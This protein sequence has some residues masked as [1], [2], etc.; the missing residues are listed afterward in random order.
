ML[1]NK[2]YREAITLLGEYNRRAVE[3]QMD[4]YRLKIR[5]RI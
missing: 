1:N 3:G 5:S 4:V 2:Q